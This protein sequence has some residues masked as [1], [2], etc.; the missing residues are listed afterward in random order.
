M[1]NSVDTDLSPFY[2]I[3]KH[4]SLSAQRL[5]E[6]NVLP[7]YA[8]WFPRRAQISSTSRRI[9]K[10]TQDKKAPSAIRQY[11]RSFLPGQKAQIMLSADCSNVYIL[12]TLYS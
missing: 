2:F 3:R 5:P 8:A 1:S 7:L 11:H 10:I 12:F 4:R 9:P 6:R